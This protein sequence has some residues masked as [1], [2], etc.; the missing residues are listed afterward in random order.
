MELQLQIF[1]SKVYG[2]QRFRRDIHHMGIQT[3]RYL[4]QSNAVWHLDLT[5]TRDLFQD[6]SCLLGSH[7][8]LCLSFSPIFRHGGIPGKP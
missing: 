8:A 1:G 7:L 6:C 4:M 5:L 2:V 3:S